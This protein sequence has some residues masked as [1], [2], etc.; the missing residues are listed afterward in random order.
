MD[1][2]DSWRY[3]A[4]EFSRIFQ[5]EV[6]FTC[7]SL[8]M[9]RE[10]C[11]RLI[12]YIGVCLLAIIGTQIRYL[13]RLTSCHHQYDLGIEKSIHLLFSGF[14]IIVDLQMHMNKRS[15]HSLDH[16]GEDMSEGLQG[17]PMHTDHESTIWR[18]DTDIDIL[19]LYASLALL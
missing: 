10:S 4:L 12:R 9:S 18:L 14:H 7:F 8:T 2:R 6:T 15:C 3:R 17:L 13:G 5:D 19:T 1:R 11:D 16:T